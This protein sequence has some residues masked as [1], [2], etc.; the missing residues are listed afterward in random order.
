VIV[1]AGGVS[2]AGAA[3]VDPLRAELAAGLAWRA[4]PEVR[5]SELGTHG[6]RIGAAVLAFRAGGRGSVVDSWSRAALLA[7]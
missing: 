1:L 5:L 6:G 4:A 2:R 7:E 3:L